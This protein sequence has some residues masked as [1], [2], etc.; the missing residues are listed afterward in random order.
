MFVFVSLRVN[1]CYTFA[2]FAAID[3]IDI[4]CLMMGCPFYLVLLEVCLLLAIV[5]LGYHIVCG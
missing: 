1:S 5:V 3:F 4:R 2:G